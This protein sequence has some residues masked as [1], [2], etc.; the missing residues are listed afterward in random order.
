MS[1][2]IEQRIAKVQQLRELGVD[3]Y[4]YGFRRTH[5]SDAVREAFEALEASGEEVALCGRIML[6]RRMGKATFLHIQDGGGRLQL[7]FK[8]DTLGEAYAHLKKVEVGDFIGIRGAAFRTRTGEPTVEARELTVLC[9]AIRPLPEKFHSLRD[10]ETRYRRRELDL[11]MNAEVAE[12]FRKR[13]RILTAVREFMTARGFFEVETPLVQMMYGGAEARP[14]VTHVNALDAPA[15]LSISPELYLKRLIVGGLEKVFTISKVFRNEGIDAT[16]NPE[17]TMMESYEA[18][19]DYEDVM[20]LA[21]ELVAHACRAVHGGTVIEFGEHRIDLTPP[22][23]RAGVFELIAE[24]CDGFDARRASVEELRARLVALGVTPDPAQSHGYLVLELFDA[25][26]QPHLIQPT[27]VKDYPRE[28]SPLCKAHRADAELIERFEPFVNGW[29]IGNAYSELNDP[30]EQRRLLE[31]QSAKLR[32]G[33]ETAS[34]MDED[35]VCA[36]ETGMP[37]TGGLGIGMDRIVML[38]VGATSIRDV[39]FFPFMKRAAAGAD[40]GEGA[41]EE[42][43][44]EAPAEG[45]AEGEA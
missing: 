9:K 1:D 5:L 21:E 12:T 33:L 17:F 19:A 42:G 45:R 41:G 40:D 15:Y 34:P 24:R 8:R 44:G 31:E 3:P 10:K 23:R 30:V 39:I 11:I 36:I 32:G 28:T 22:W 35:F 6:M 7:Y 18:Y 14:F 2:L 43:E 38:L 20:R 29:E 37:P 27:F 13:S 16:H 4:P 26:V 25:A